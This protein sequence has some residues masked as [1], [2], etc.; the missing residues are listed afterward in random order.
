MIQTINKLEKV[1]ER[2]RSKN[3]VILLNQEKDIQA[4]SEMNKRLEDFRRESL[5]KEKNSQ[6]SAGSVILTT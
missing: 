2:L 6:I 5:K 3:A 1:K 4:T